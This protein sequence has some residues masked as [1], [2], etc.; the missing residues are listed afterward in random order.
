MALN[1]ISEPEQDTML[2]QQI[3]I[4]RRM[5]HAGVVSTLGAGTNIDA[6]DMGVLAAFEELQEEGEPD[7]IVELIGLYL[8]EAPQRI[9]AIQCAVANADRLCLKRA[10]HSLKG[11]SG[12][13]GV[14]PLAAICEE[15]EHLTDETF[16]P[17]ARVLV[18]RLEE[19]FVR[20]HKA[21][22]SEHV[23]RSANSNGI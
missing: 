7:L 8:Q 5:G 6:V 12:T 1:S 16:F 15:L 14:R 4:N 11:S 21:L 22:V 13:L 2:T 18:S 17:E 9:E 20:A 23:R 10:A 3:A 19:E